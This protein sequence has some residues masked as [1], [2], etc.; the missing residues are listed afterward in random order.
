M[1]VTEP[2]SSTESNEPRSRLSS[3]FVLLMVLGAAMFA[4]WLAYG[5]FQEGH[6]HL[7]SSLPHDRSA[8]YTRALSVAMDLRQGNLAHL[9]HD[10]DSSRNWGPL[11]GVL[12]GVVLAIGGLDYRLAVLPSLLAWIGCAVFAFLVAR[13]AV[14]RGGNLA[15]IVAALF[16]LASPAHHAFAT[17][18]MLESLGACLSMAALYWYLV[19]VQDHSRRA[20]CFLGVTLSLLLVHKYNYWMLVILSLIAAELTRQPR[21]YCQML[22]RVVGLAFSPA[23]WL[24]QL[25]Q[26]LTY[27]IIVTLGLGLAILATGGTTISFASKSI[28]LHS[29]HNFIHV[30]YILLFL[31]LCLWWRASGKSL[32]AMLDDTP[33]TLVY[34]HLWPVACWFLL[35]KRLSYFFF[36]IGPTNTPHYESGFFSALEKYGPWLADHYHV[37]W[38]FFLG[39][40]VLAGIALFNFRRSR[41]GVALIF[42]FALLATVLTCNHPH[43]ASRFAHSWAATI[44]VL[45]GAGVACLLYN[46]F[47]DRI[48]FLRPGLL[49][50]CVGGLAI[51]FLPSVAERQYVTHGGPNYDRPSN[52]EITDRYLPLLASSKKTLV[53]CNKVP[54]K[55]FVHCTF[56]ERYQDFDAIEIDIKGFGQDYDANSQAFD[57]WLKSTRCDTLVYIDVPENSTF[58]LKDLHH[59]YDHVA[60]FLSGQTSFTLAETIPMPAYGCA[61]SVWKKK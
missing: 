27:A 57:H 28:S 50:A 20:A 13:R 33:R 54:M 5:Q 12:A 58:Y 9:I 2:L 53:V 56:L 38:A 40:L 34:W 23:W 26:P 48:K 19:A 17:D 47:A 32:A 21:V 52:L 44:W 59:R 4:A 8:H 1:S 24:A 51:F 14:P 29:A 6:R 16:V 49:T 37:G 25:R 41:P 36:Y 43:R 42:W 11:H 7:W 10:I 30:A 31:R 3:A 45:A 55:Q 18:I 61:V 15:G 46:R 35:P 60:E 22:L 39:A